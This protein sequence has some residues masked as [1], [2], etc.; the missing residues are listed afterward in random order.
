MIEGSQR[1]QDTLNLIFGSLVFLFVL[2]VYTL[3]MNPSV[4]FWDS[5][6]Y[7]ATS[8]IMGVPHPPGTP[9]YVLV[10][11]VFSMIPF[12]SVAQNV[13]WLSAFSSAVAIL[14]VY[15]I[16]VKI[17]RR[18]FPLEQDPNNR[19]MSYAAGAIGALLAAFATTFW[20]NAIE[21]EV[22]AGACAIMAFSI[23][24][25]FRWH[26]RLG[27]GSEDGLLLLISYIVGLGVGIHLAVAIVAW[28]A[29]L[30]VFICR[31]NYLK[32]WNYIGWAIVTLSLGLGINQL[33][34]L[35]APIV[36]GITLLLYL[37]RGRIS[38]LPF[39]ASILFMLGLSVHFFLLI[40]SNLDPAINEGAPKDWESLWL[41]LTRD[42]YKP[43]S[44]LERRAPIPYQIDFMWLRYMWW[45]FTLFAVKGKAFFVLPI[46]LA[47]I[48][49]VVHFL[50]DKKTAAVLWALFVFLG[51]AMVFY[52]NFKVG[53]VRERDYFFV[54]NFM[55]LSIWVGI[56]AM[57]VTQTLGELLKSRRLMTAVGVSLFVGM[58]LLPLRHNLRAHDRSDYYFAHNYAHNML[59]TLEPDAILF[60]NGDN[61][62]FPLWYIQEV[63]GF[64]KDVRVINLSLL[65]TPWY[66]D[67]LK[68][69]EP[70]IPISWTDEQIKT[71][72][73]A[74]Q[75]TYARFNGQ[76]IPIS[77]ET[78]RAWD[79]SALNPLLE[80]SNEVARRDNRVAYVKD[81]AV[82]DIVKTNNWERPLYL[83][84]TVPERMGLNKQ[85]AME[86][87]V[88]RINPTGQGETLNVPVAEKNLFEVY[89]YDG[90][91]IR[92]EAD[93][94]AAW[95][96]DTTTYLDP[97]GSKLVQNYAA[98]FSRLA[99][100]YVDSDRD[101]EALSAVK[102]AEMISPR[103]AGISMARGFIYERIGDLEGAERY[104]REMLAKQPSPDWQLNHRLALLILRQGREE[105]AI[106]MLQETVRLAPDRFEPVQSLLT[107]YYNQNRYP[108]AL[109]V[110]EGWLRAHPQDA[111]V[112]QLYDQLRQSIQAQEGE[113]Q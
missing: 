33:T 89:K 9:L 14:F 11:R 75:L 34:F 78:Q 105:E 69:L 84:V 50:K 79:Q 8:Y 68:N 87:L 102:K 13:N 65:N 91:V 38:R 5:G 98:A 88:Y 17:S 85:L 30:F 80:I 92:D 48:G 71:I 15:L 93:P 4:P 18:I 103:F 7:I 60:T 64:R 96:P 61:D 1:S 16:G 10:G 109:Q 83:A 57:W 12:G 53:E 49:G 59:A 67:Q 19:A 94:Q 113:G 25:V 112:R 56:G 107:V 55:F 46:L 76:T 100:Y 37:V 39:W 97:N 74:F 3:T 104:Y 99:L 95:L 42:Q 111:S 70:K 54:Q 110:L 82:D 29:V 77:I 108:E 52:M 51:P 62:T 32:Q 81:F 41:M 66:I 63:E 20:D 22:Y 47:A 27:E 106:Q 45:N 44:P 86:G 2:T 21:A 40:R 28:P 35:W 43:G 26:E 101:E 58:S 72:N 24:L 6:E 90:L 31:P 73:E 23:W 36:L